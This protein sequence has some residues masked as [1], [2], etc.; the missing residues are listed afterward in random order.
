MPCSPARSRRG[1]FRPPGR[2]SDRIG[3]G[4]ILRHAFN[5]G[6]RDALGAQQLR[7]A[8]LDR[9]DRR[10][11]D[12]RGQTADQSVGDPLAGPRRGRAKPPELL[13]GSADL[14]ARVRLARAVRRSRRAALRG[15]HP[16]HF[17][18]RPRTDL[19]LRSRLGRE[20]RGDAGTLLDT[21]RERFWRGDPGIH[22]KRSA[23]AHARAERRGRE[24]WNQ[25]LR[26]QV[27]R[28]IGSAQL[29]RRCFPPRDHRLPRP[30]RGRERPRKCQAQARARRRHA[31]RFHRER[32]EAAG[33]GPGGAETRPGGAEPAASRCHLGDSVQYPQGCGA[34]P[35]RRDRGAPARRFRQPAVCRLRR[36]PA[37]RAI[38][39]NSY[40]GAECT[41]FVGRR[42]QSRPFLLRT[43]LAL[44]ARG[45][46]CRP[47]PRVHAGK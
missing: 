42:R 47:T 31:P 8:G 40:P 43:G 28:P 6:H 30:Q 33:A 16:R 46:T 18:G 29:H 41:D 20:D 34:E 1:S 23:R 12:P 7:S 26:S 44:V 5:R 45:R 27:R 37:S 38:P 35:G 32:S 36:E 22:R 9:P 24:L 19:Q 11:C 15:R 39:C 25:P 2:R 10:R 3:P 14:F 21:L 17:P 4:R 13:T